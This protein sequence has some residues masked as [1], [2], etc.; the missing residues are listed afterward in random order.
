M[1]ASAVYQAANAVTIP[2][3]PPTVQK[4]APGADVTP[5]PGNPRSAPMV[6]ERKVRNRI[7]KT[8]ISAMLILK[9]PK[10]IKPVKIVQPSRK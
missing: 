9:V 1:P 4:P 2:N 6:S 8:T 10:N 5:G 3:Q 7:P